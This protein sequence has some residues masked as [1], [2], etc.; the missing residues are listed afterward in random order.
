[1][2]CREH[3][4]SLALFAPPNAQ[5][6]YSPVF[7]YEMVA[8]ELFRMFTRGNNQG[9]ARMFLRLGGLLLFEVGQGLEHKVR[10]MMRRVF[11]TSNTGAYMSSKARKNART[12]HT[13][14][15][16]CKF[17]M[18]KEKLNDQKGMVRCLV[19]ERI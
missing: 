11:C 1:M 3:E 6:S 18:Y 5:G 9:G 8:K 12:H 10:T 4:P 15:G 2:N 19:Y 17:L 16:E 13:A 7:C 14:A